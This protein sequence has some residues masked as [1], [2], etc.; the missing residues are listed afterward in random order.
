MQ[1][2]DVQTSIWTADDD[3]IDLCHEAKLLYIWTFTNPRCNMAGLY[4][5]AKRVMQR[6]TTIPPK[7]FEIAF[8]Q[9]VKG[10]FLLYEDGVLWVRTRVKHLWS[11]HQNYAKQIAKNVVEVAPHP[12]A[13]QFLAEYRDRGWLRKELSSIPVESVKLELK[14]GHCPIDT[15][16]DYGSGYGVVEESPTSTENSQDYSRDFDDWLADHEQVTGMRPPRVG[17]KA[18]QAVEASFAARRTEGYPLDDLKL[19]TLGAQRDDYRR[20]RGYVDAESVLRPTKVAKLIGLGRRP[21]ASPPPPPQVQARQAMR[22]KLQG[23]IDN[24]DAA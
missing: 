3:F 15:V 21:V 12:L 19:A 24:E 18:R 16:H 20:E 1:R 2:E 14:S 6:E 22:A 9:L 13:E 4:R 7:R 17:T 11:K 10:G 23:V 5:V 8:E